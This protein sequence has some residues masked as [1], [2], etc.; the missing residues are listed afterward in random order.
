MPVRDKGPFFII[1][2]YDSSAALRTEQYY[3]RSAWQVASLTV[4]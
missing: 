1:Y 2:P 4:R 3:A